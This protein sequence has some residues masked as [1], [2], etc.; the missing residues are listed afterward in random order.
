MGLNYTAVD[1]TDD[2]TRARMKRGICF[3]AVLGGRLIGS[4]VYRAAS[5][6]AGS[7]FLERAEVASLGQFGVLPEHQRGGIGSRLMQAAENRAHADGAAEIALDTAEPAMH[8]IRYYLSRGYRPIE[9]AQ[10]PGKVYRSV[11]M[12]KRL[13]AD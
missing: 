5:V 12:S 3:V 7:P 4:V 11:I 8:L 13:A 1:Q 6:T 2:V 10:W 9:T